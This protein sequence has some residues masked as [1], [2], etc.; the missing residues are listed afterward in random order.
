MALFVAEILCP[1]SVLKMLARVHIIEGLYKEYGHFPGPRE[2]S[3]KV[4]RGSTE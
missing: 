2:L 4:R 3:V 1:L